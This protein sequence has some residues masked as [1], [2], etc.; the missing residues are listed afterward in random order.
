MLTPEE[1][2]KIFNFAK[3]KRLRFCLDYDPRNWIAW[4]QE[5][6]RETPLICEY[7]S[8]SENSAEEAIKR[9][10]FEIENK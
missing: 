10:I 3:E 9:L 4:F 5:I 6:E 1:F 8:L 2:N 7:M